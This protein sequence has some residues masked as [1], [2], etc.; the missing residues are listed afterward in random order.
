MDGLAVGIDVVWSSERSNLKKKDVILG[1]LDSWT[2]TRQV[3][4]GSW[5]PGQ[6]L[7]RSWIPG[8]PPDRTKLGQGVKFVTF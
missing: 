6:R 4:D 1:F 2:D 7:D 3:L 8:E 5:I